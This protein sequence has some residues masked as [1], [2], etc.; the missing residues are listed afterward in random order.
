MSE[1]IVPHSGAPDNGNGKEQKES[2]EQLILQVVI[3]GG[4]LMPSIGNGAQLR[5]ISHAIRILSLML[6][7]RI[8]QAQ[9]QANAHKV[10]PVKSGIMDFARKGFRR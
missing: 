1:I 7:T 6:D 10:Q 5:D 2:E 8:S 9:A 4:Q 3:K